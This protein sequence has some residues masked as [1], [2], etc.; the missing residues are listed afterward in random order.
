MTLVAEAIGSQPFQNIPERS[1][2]EAEVE[3]PTT[4]IFRKALLNR[5]GNMLGKLK[6]EDLSS[7][8][9]Q[10]KGIGNTINYAAGLL[11]G[12]SHMSEVQLKAAEAEVVK[13]LHTAII[14]HPLAN[15]I[16]VYSYQNEWVRQDGRLR[17]KS[18]FGFLDEIVEE[19]IQNTSGQIPAFEIKR[20]KQDKRI[21]NI[22]TQER[23][24]G[25]SGEII[26]FSPAPE[27][28]DSREVR[29]RGYQ[30]HDQISTF[31]L[32]E[33]GREV[34]TIYW[35]PGSAPYEYVQLA[36]ELISLDPDNKEL[37]E[38]LTKV[39]T[40]KA[41]ESG[42]DTNIMAMSNKFNKAQTERIMRFVQEK[43]NDMQ[44]NEN[45][46]RYFANTRTKFAIEN[47][48]IHEVYKAALGVCKGENIQSQLDLIYQI[49]EQLQYELVLHIQH[50]N[51]E[52]G[53]INVEEYMKM[54]FEERQE[55][56]RKTGFR[57]TGCGFA[58]ENA[59]EMM[60][61]LSGKDERGPLMFKCPEC[62]HINKR[63]R[64]ELIEYCQNPTTGKHKIPRC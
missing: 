9:N 63:P 7:I 14:E 46:I 32:D 5:A 10:H 1:F 60:M 62:G 24:K 44:A 52:A 29:A 45:E 3:N 33:E 11:E 19:G 37:N 41:D 39:V 28:V 42:I 50:L 17:L 30:G 35:F 16:G 6:V 25:Y 34:T 40:G 48:L 38:Q 4:V 43:Q 57:A 56:I 2:H 53:E 20:N 26:K 27:N 23:R 22:L 18:D 55:M 58:S 31:K 21:L 47:N 54:S 59:G 15:A 51:N 61:A 12:A 13:N 8:K 49:I 64:G 36:R